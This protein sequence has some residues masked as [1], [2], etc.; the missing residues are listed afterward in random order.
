MSHPV[1]RVGGFAPLTTPGFAPAGRHLRAGLQLGVED[2]NQ[3]GGL[4]GQLVELSLRD[5]GEARIARCPP[6]TNSRPRGS[7]RLSVSST[8]PWHARWPNW[9]T[10]SGCHSC[11]PRR[12]ST[13]SRP[14]QRTASRVSRRRSRMAGGS[15]PTICWAPDTDAL[16][17]RLPRTNTG[18]PVPRCSRRVVVRSGRRARAST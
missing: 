15:M 2:F 13:T 18:R 6:S 5:T 16:R 12:R 4:D 8:A 14:S 1:V 9:R 7:R 3:A 17:S 11:V 10:A